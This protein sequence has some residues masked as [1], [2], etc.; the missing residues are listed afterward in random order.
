[1]LYGF[2]EVQSSKFK[3]QVSLVFWLVVGSKNQP[4]SRAMRPT[5]ASAI[6]RE[7]RKTYVRAYVFTTD[8]DQENTKYNP[9]AN[10]NEKAK[11]KTHV[12]IDGCDSRVHNGVRRT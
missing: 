7:C 6:S 4:Q 8:R 10:E 1:M 11:T 5:A 3:G 12:W 9:N 2:C